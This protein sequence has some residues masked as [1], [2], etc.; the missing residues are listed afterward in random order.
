MLQ[1]L[2]PNFPGSC[3]NSRELI[4]VL[5]GYISRY[6]VGKHLGA[7]GSKSRSGPGMTSPPNNHSLFQGSHALYHRQILATG[8]F[9]HDS[10]SLQ[11]SPLIVKAITPSTD[12]RIV[13]TA[14]LSRQG[15]NFQSWRRRN[16]VAS[17]RSLKSSPY[18]HGV[19]TG[20]TQHRKPR[21]PGRRIAVPFS[22]TTLIARP[23][24]QM[25]APPH[26]RTRRRQVQPQNHHRST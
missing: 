12:S 22:N 23:R 4:H 15:G 14:E 20:K 1:A 9:P 26:H 2:H 21:L 5:N 16:P 24:R 11:N 18:L 13:H 7:L 17:Q 10:P 6:K 25:R 8:R 3:S 19:W